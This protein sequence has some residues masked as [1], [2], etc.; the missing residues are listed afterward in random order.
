MFFNLGKT[1]GNKHGENVRGLRINNLNPV[2]ILTYNFLFF[3]IS[4][5][6]TFSPLLINHLPAHYSLRIIQSMQVLSMW[7]SQ[8]EVSILVTWLL[9]ANH[10]P[11]L[12]YHIGQCVSRQIIHR[13]LAHT[14]KVPKW[15]ILKFINQ[16]INAKNYLLKSTNWHFKYLN[17]SSHI[18][19]CSKTWVTWGNY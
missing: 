16:P 5:Y 10:S 15:N 9:T 7:S 8:S 3:R 1:N 2:W 6:L 18:F 11:V 19:E 13:V 14:I 17:G 4:R 12:L